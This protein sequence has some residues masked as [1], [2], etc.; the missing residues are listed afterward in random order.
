MPDHT[1]SPTASG[2]AV[3]I[4]ELAGQEISRDF[5]ASLDR[6]GL[7]ADAIRTP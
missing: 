3:K 6:H 4:F 5:I 7:I 2:D 1:R